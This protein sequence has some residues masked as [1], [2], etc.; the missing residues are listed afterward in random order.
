LK[1]AAQ[2]LSLVGAGGAETPQAQ[3]K[4]VFFAPFCSQKGVLLFLT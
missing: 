4:K 1:K 2:K 3:F